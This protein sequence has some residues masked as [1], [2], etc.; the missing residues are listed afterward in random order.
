MNRFRA[1]VA[2]YIGV[3]AFASLV[4]VGAGRLM[5]WQGLLYGVLA[6]LGTS[7]THLLM[8]TG[9]GLAERRIREAHRGQ[10]WDKRLLGALFAV[11]LVMFVVAGM[12]SGRFRWTG[13]LPLWVT[14]VGAALMIKGQI[15]FALARRENVFF[16]S[17]VQVQTELGH[18]VCD[19]GLYR[20]V[21]HPGYL[22]MLLS[23]LAFPLVMGMSW[24]AVPCAVCMGLLV[25]R[26]VRE[27]QFLLRALPGY[28][29]YAL[30]TRFK[31]VPGVF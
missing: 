2:S 29:E 12:D 14:I 13:P 11:N 10:D 4:F 9:S 1:V 7:I 21:R 20:L 27:D 16:S 23:V 6:L 24:A 8:P 28:A 5:Y 15:I 3:L 22:G 31:L 26:T 19:T 17:T 25:I 30:K 18:Q